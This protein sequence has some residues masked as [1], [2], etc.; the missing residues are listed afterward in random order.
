MTAQKKVLIADDDASIRTVLTHA[1]QREGYDVSV[2]DNGATLYRWV[3]EGD[4]D[5]V[6]TDVMMPGENGLDLI[7]KIHR[8]RPDLKVIVISAQNVLTTAMAAAEK[9]ALDYLPKPFDVDTLLSTV[10][11]SLSPPNPRSKKNEAQQDT[12]QAL[13]K[14]FVIGQSPALQDIY[15][16]VARL[17]DSDL[18]VMISGES[19]TGKEVLART[20]HQYSRFSKGPF[21]AV[22]MAAIPRE[23]IESE[24]FGHEKGAFTGASARQ[25]GRF[26]Q[27]SGGT[28]FLDEI[29]D[30]PFEAQTRLLRVLQEGEFSTVGGRKSIRTNVR[31]IAATNKDLKKLVQQGNF[32]E[33]LYY[34]L[35]VVPLQLPP[36]RERCADIPALIRHFSRDSIKVFEPQAMKLLQEYKWP[37]NIR[38]LENIVRRLVALHPQEIIDAEA[39]LSILE[40]D[41][42]TRQIDTPDDVNL[43]IKSAIDAYFVNGPKDGRVHEDLISLTE[44]LLIEKVLTITGG[45]QIKAAEMLGLN[46]NTLR[47]KIRELS[48][49][50]RKT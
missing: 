33:D 28:L 22:N 37:G 38:E 34:R 26:E 18:T 42:A 41:V 50:F 35:N 32:R 46:R 39:V 12:A 6:I 25:P 45:N 16:T 48:I 47:K 43:I 5:I 30:M 23:L 29:G 15:K 21:I 40:K 9:G 24:L 3:A 27:A 13:D 8:R 10:R 19:G 14:S 17:K 4:G 7:P 49:E 11:K 36:L 2:T 31:I 20:V 1:F 44:K